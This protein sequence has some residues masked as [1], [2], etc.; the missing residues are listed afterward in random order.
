MKMVLHGEGLSEEIF[1]T[2]A[3]SDAVNLIHFQ[4]QRKWVDIAE[5]GR[6]LNAIVLSFADSG[7]VLLSS[8]IS[9]TKFE[10]SHQTSK[11]M[12]KIAFFKVS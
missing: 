12:T 3:W 7:I 11:F 9:P 4:F 6:S 8:T 5:N 2:I 10:L 1:L